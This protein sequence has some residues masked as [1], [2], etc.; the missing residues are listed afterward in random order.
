MAWNNMSLKGERELAKHG[1]KGEK[2]CPGC[3]EGM[4]SI[5]HVFLFCIYYKVVDLYGDGAFVYETCKV[6]Q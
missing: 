2:G 6:T 4:E 5:T 3:G 1:V